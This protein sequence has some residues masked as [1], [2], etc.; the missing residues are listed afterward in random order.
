[1]SWIKRHS[2]LA[3]ILMLTL[4]L[5]VSVE[6]SLR[7]AGIGYGNSPIELD[8]RLHH[9]HPRNYEFVSY[10]PGGEYIGHKIFYDELGYRVESKNPVL[11]KDD[12]IR[13]IAFLGDGF[14]EAN[15]V[16]WVQSFVGIIESKNSN[17]SVRNFGVASYSPVIFLVQMN[18]EV[19]SFQPTDVVVQIFANDFNND[20]EYLKRANSET[21]SEIKTV[22]ERASIRDKVTKI[23]RYSYF[24]RL[25]RKL[26]QQLIFLSLNKSNSSSQYS[27]LNKVVL[28]NENEKKQTYE[29]ILL[30]KDLADKI[31]ARIFFFVVP[32]KQLTLQN[33]CC[34]AD[35]LA[36]EFYNFT[37][38]HNLNLI[39][40]PKA[41]GNYPD[42]SNL[43][44]E[45][46]VHFTAEGN[47]VTAEAI[48]NKLR[49]SEEQ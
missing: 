12:T 26:Q 2:K 6:I 5:A 49:L 36:V 27:L 22:S 47:L 35:T 30:L 29:A 1:M 41:F 43:F 34:E 11:R 3:L 4:F 20:K 32:N 24:A 46:D 31:N 28:T 7:F 25:V 38:A 15:S 45:R 17:L 18:N 40:I 42:Q 14:T 39:D 44:F 19:K 21:L 33:Q 23:L 10:H 8:Q 37:E 48:S 9:L 16:S 13:R